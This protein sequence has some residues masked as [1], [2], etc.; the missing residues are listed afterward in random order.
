MAHILVVDDEV[1]LAVLLAGLLEDEG[2]HV[3]TAS[4]GQAALSA[5]QNQRPDLVVTDFMMPTMTG[6]ELAEAVRSDGALADL[7]IILVSGA[8]GAIARQRPELFQA[9]LDKPYR[10]DAMLREVAKCIKRS[11]A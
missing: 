9:V 7:P 10:N 1:L 4:N 3:E 6:L 2:Y 5:I 8:Q 11:G